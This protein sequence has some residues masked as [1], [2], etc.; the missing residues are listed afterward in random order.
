MIL[1][2]VIDRLILQWT[3]HCLAQLRDTMGARLPIL[4]EAELLR[5]LLHGQ[6]EVANSLES[7]ST[8]LPDNI[9][10]VLHDDFA[11]LM[12][13]A[14]RDTLENQLAPS[15]ES[16]SRS[17]EFFAEKSLKNQS[18]GMRL[19]ADRFFK[20]LEDLFADRFQTFDENITRLF[21]LQDKTAE[22]MNGLLAGV[23]DAIRLQETVNQGNAADDRCAGSVP[24][25]FGRE[26][27]NV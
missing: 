18:E 26:H 2:F 24:R 3:V 13:E 5:V 14:Y 22:S 10:E 27:P 7:L 8:H 15:I 6:R 1:W 23:T 20:R 4:D 19:L 25:A 11:P 17:V 12:F 9:R 21:A 16:L